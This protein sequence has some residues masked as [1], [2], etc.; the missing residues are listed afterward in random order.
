MRSREFETYK[1]R[2]RAAIR[3]VLSE[4]EPGQLDEIGFPAYSHANPVINWLFWKRLHTVIDYIEAEAPYDRVLDF[5]CGSGVMLHFLSKVSRSVVAA[6]VDLVP[7]KHMMRYVPL[8]SNVQVLEISAEALSREAPGS[9]DLI[10]ALDVLEHVPDLEKSASGLLR[11]LRSGRQLVISGPT[12]NLLYKFGRRLAGPEY[13]GEYHE[14]GVEEIRRLL[15]SRA[16]LRQIAT[17]YWPAPLF[18]I[19][20]ARP[21]A[22]QH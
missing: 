21:V 18:Q 12:E 4:A 9:F 5:G 16:E 3:Q 22:A 7:L 2:F 10:I 14:R 8:P 15:E 6:D 20:A 1:A 17:L 19:F 11:L 13:S